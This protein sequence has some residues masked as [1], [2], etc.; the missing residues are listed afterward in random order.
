MV[1]KKT[2][3]KIEHLVLGLVVLFVM[4]F[5]RRAAVDAGQRSAD[6]LFR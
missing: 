5:L 3:L 1:V 6:Q 2:G 4:A